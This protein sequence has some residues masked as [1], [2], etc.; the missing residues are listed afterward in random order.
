MIDSAEFERGWALLQAAMPDTELPDATREL[1][2]HAMARV[3]AGSFV[4]GILSLISAPGFD[5]RRLPS[6]YEMREECRSWAAAPRGEPYVGDIRLREYVLALRPG[7]GH[8][9]QLSPEEAAALVERVAARAP[10]PPPPPPPPAPP[11]PQPA[12][13]PPPRRPPPGSGNAGHGVL[14]GHAALAPIS[15][16]RISEVE[17]AE[18]R[19]RLLEETDELLGAG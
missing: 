2:R 8:G 3:P 14:L 17:W 18:R 19:R 11:P 1:Y 4:E 5:N 12:P 16:S 9:P 15:A 6:L 13:P 7:N 10:A